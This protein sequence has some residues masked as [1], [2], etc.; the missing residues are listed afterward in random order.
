MKQFDALDPNLFLYVG[1]FLGVLVVFEGL[2][3]LIFGGDPAEK[4]RSKRIK[5]LRKGMSQE[6]V[7]TLLRHRPREN[8]L[9][10]IPV[11]GTLPSKMRQAG[12]TMKPS[13]FLGVC[14]AL[15][16][17]VL[18][19]GTVSLG[20]KIAAV[21]AVLS[22]MVI[23]M[24]LINII[25]KR[26]V[27]RFSEQLPDALDM[28]MRGLRVGHP[29]NTTIANVAQNMPDPIGTEFGIM[30]D[31]ITYG[32]ELTDAMADLADRID[33]EDMHYLAVSVNIQHGTGG[34][35]AKMLGT[36]SKVIRRRFAMRRK[37]RALSSEGRISASILSVLP[38]AM[39][40]ATTVTAPDYYS[41]VADDP[42]FKPVVAAILA[43]VTVNYLVLRR[44]VHFRI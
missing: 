23:P 9:S 42:L 16:A 32:D 25:R 26:R 37:I 14:L 6:K 4:T 10:K 22:C 3:Q 19:L 30:S 35:L 2:R 24:S 20:P 11:Y 29:L 1:I 7:L 15:A 18:L 36:L 33:Q 44:L 31:Q 28:M 43:L 41:G 40:G 8:L 39:Y 21:V 12:M 13:V 27:Q 5:L 38:L 34:N 17:A